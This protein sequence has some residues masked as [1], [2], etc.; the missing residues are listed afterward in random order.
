MA[1][2][3][4]TVTPA[5]RS[6][7]RKELLNFVITEEETFLDVRMRFKE[8]LR[9]VAVQG[10]VADVADRLQTLLGSPPEKFDIL[11][12][13]FFAQTPAPNID[14]VWDRMFDIERMEKRKTLHLGHL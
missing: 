8:L 9:K 3:Y 13:S 1:I 11:R 14:Y 12:E 6:T 2:D 10:G 4:N 7:A 5:Q